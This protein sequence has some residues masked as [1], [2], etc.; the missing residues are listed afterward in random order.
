[1]AVSVSVLGQEQLDPG[2]HQAGQATAGTGMEPIAASTRPAATTTPPTAVSKP[3]PGTNRRPGN[4]CR[5]T[6]PRRRSR[7]RRTWRAPDRLPPPVHDRHRVGDASGTAPTPTPAASSSTGWS[8]GSTHST[9][10]TP[11][12]P[13]NSPYSKPNSVLATPAPA[14][15]GHAARHRCEP[16]RPPEPQQPGD[17]HQ[18]QAVS[19]VAEHHPDHQHVCRAGQQRRIHVPVRHRAV[20][21]HQRRERPA[22][23]TAAAQQRGRVDAARCRQRH[24]RGPDAGQPIGES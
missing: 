15:N 5:G 16:A 1:M 9:G 10:T 17:R 18:Q 11:V 24:H 4:R 23:L 19:R 8:S 12:G 3:T 20:P 22:H 6:P 14:T 13:K 2:L 7:T 21:A